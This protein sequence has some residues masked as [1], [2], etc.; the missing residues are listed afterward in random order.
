MTHNGARKHRSC[1][2]PIAGVANLTDFASLSVPRDAQDYGVCE[3]RSPKDV[4]CPDDLFEFPQG[5]RRR[6]RPA[7]SQER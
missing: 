4:G 7:K 3:T 5:A 2:G 6:H 1:Q